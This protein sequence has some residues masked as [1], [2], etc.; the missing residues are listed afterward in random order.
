MWAPNKFNTFDYN[1]P[2]IRF[3]GKGHPLLGDN[4][5][6]QTHSAN[7]REIRCRGRGACHS[8]QC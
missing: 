7:R 1:F 5:V 8:P 2:K 4:A 3:C 6:L